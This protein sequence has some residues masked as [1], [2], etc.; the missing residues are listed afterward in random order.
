MALPTEP[1]PLETKLSTQ[2]MFYRL[3]REFNRL[4]RRMDEHMAEADTAYPG[5]DRRRHY[6]HHVNIDQRELDRKEFWKK[7][8]PQVVGGTFLAGLGFFAAAILFFVRNGGH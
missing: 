6:D 8:I 2:E 4:E 7:V 3:H 1:A 5:A